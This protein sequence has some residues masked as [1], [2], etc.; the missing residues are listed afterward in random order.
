MDEIRMS[1]KERER[2]E[3][4]GRVKR[5]ELAWVKGAEWLGLSY[6]QARRA[7]RRYRQH[8]ARELV[9]RS[10]E[11]RSN[12][13]KPAPRG[14]RCSSGTASATVIL[15]R[16][17]R[18][19]IW[20]GTVTGWITRRCGVG[21][22]PRGCGRSGGA[23]GGIDVGGRAKSMSGRCCR[24]MARSTTGSRVVAAGRC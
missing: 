23:G 20:R 21:Y 4:F 10:R 13:A 17:W 8:G 6:R 9:H 12:R 19:S 22:A 14:R 2:L 24:W 18:R 16:R 1:R 5:G 15:V 7:Y 11:R 3:V